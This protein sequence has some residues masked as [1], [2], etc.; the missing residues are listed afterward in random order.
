MPRPNQP[1]VTY[2]SA[3]TSYLED[4]TTPRPETSRSSNGR[5][6]A[7]RPRT[8]VSTLASREQQIICA[9]SESRGISPVVGL[10]FVNLTTTEAT[11]C[12]ISDNQTFTRTLHKLV[13]YEPTEILFMTTA[14]QPKSKLFSI[15]EHNL[16]HLRISIIDRKYWAETSGLEYIKELAFK[17]D[18]EAIKVLKYIELALSFSFPFHSLRIKY[19]TSEGSMMIDLST[20]ASLELI[21]NLQNPKSKDCLYGLLNQT[22]TPMGA[23]LLKSSLLQPSTDSDTLEKRYNALDELATREDVFFAVRQ[24]K[25]T[26][27]IGF[28]LLWVILAPRVSL[29]YE[30]VTIFPTK[31]TIQYS[32]QSINNVIALKQYVKSIPAVFEA[33]ATVNSELLLH[34]NEVRKV[35]SSLMC[36]RSLTKPSTKISRF[37]ASHWTFGTSSGVNGL[38][39][40]ARQTYKEANADAYQLVTD[41]G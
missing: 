31:P 5:P 13:V 23:R 27:L 30:Q 4:T 40:V 29:A 10:A 17:Q 2:T 15:V 41:L 25:A 1:R 28:S 14:A 32:E 18:V 34:I 9:I 26:T 21:Q 12:Q 11:M 22:L 3:S 7:G 19:E 37:K 38:L 8:A 20:I 35:P 24:G 16:P 39:D 6:R 36:K 33:L